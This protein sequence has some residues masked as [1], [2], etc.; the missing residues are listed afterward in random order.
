MTHKK[1]ER[2]KH[3]RERGSA[4]ARGYDRNWQKA[5][6][7]FLREH[8]LCAECER[9]GEITAAALVDHII[10]HRGDQGLFWDEANWQALC[11][12]HHDLKTSRERREM[13]R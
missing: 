10:P 9:Q 11:G 6:K 4:S 7:R 12:R 13:A 1:Q 3:D 2:Q 5:S 8:P